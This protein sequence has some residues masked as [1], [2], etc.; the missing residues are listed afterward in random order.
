MLFLNIKKGGRKTKKNNK[1]KQK[2]KKKTNLKKQKTVTRKSKVPTSLSIFP[3]KSPQLQKDNEP[4]KLNKFTTKNVAVKDKNHNEYNSILNNRLAYKRP[5]RGQDLQIDTSIIYGP[6]VEPIKKK[7]YKSLK[8]GDVIYYDRSSVVL[9]G[10][11]YFQGHRRGPELLLKVKDI[12]YPREYLFSIEVNKLEKEN[13]YL[14]K[15]NKKTLKKKKTKKHKGGFKE[16]YKVLNGLIHKSS[17]NN[18]IPSLDNKFL[19]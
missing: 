5:A 11:F 13:L 3:D 9:R 4:T 8:K 18:W 7:N 10:P 2:T 17:N 19:L 1:K 14:V 15:N 6:V 16:T 12:V